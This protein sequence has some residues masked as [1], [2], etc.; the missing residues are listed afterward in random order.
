MVLDVLN[1]LFQSKVS[2][3]GTAVGVAGVMLGVAWLI[4]R[5]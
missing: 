2:T 3:I 5:N 4:T 1:F